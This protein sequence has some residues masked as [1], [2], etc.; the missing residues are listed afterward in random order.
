MDQL[1][2]LPSA[3]RLDR[4]A[5]DQ[6]RLRTRFKATDPIWNEPQQQ[7]KHWTPL[8]EHI[9]RL[10]LVAGELEQGSPD[11]DWFPIFEQLHLA[12][13]LNDLSCDTDITNTS[14]MCSPAAEYEDV[15]SEVAAKHLAGVITFNLV[16]AA[17]EGAVALAR[18]ADGKG[19]PKGAFGRELLLRRFG[20]RH[21]PG[22]RNAFAD[23]I[24]LRFDKGRTLQGP[25][26]RRA[27]A[28]GAL[29]ALAAEHLRQFRNALAHGDL[30]KPDPDD[31]GERSTY[32]VDDDPAIRQFPANI[33]LT[34]ILIQV[35]I[36]CALDP[37][38]LIE[39]WHDGPVSAIDY[40]TTL[41]CAAPAR[42]EPF[43][44]EEV[45]IPQPLG[46]R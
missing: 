16:W 30:R 27:A 25:E 20:D 40:V 17:Y 4:S 28:G 37:D 38:E 7:T 11:A 6:G 15:N 13:S 5:A 19:Q 14:F 2:R 32:A 9:K 43:L 35:L 36:L 12:A 41:H 42:D 46:W 33:R 10:C 1:A 39:E 45:A 34:L 23:A 26:V 31:W 8:R 24:A 22:L 44:F 3:D 29:A 18:G 21:M